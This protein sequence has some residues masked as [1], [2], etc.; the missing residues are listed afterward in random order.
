MTSEL[1]EKLFIRFYRKHFMRPK[2]LLSYLTMIWRS[3][4]SWKRFLAN[5]GGFLRFVRTDN[6]IAGLG[7]ESGAAEE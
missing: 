3:P 4:D 1:L 5:I 6:R 7:K 2:M